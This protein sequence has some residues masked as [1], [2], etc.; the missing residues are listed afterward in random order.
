MFYGDREKEEIENYSLIV[1]EIIH[2]SPSYNNSEKKKKTKKKK[3]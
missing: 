2:I 1:E 3:K